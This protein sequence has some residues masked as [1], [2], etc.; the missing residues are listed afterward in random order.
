MCVLVLW[1]LN[2]FKVVFGC[3]NEWF[4]GC[5]FILNIYIDDYIIEIFKC[6]F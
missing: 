6:V 3:V 2:V 4:G 1:Y 5:G